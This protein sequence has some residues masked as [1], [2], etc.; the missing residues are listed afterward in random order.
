[1]PSATSAA[2]FAFTERSKF[3]SVNAATR[4]LARQAACLMSD[5]AGIPRPLWSR[6]IILSDPAL[7]V[8]LLAPLAEMANAQ[9][10]GFG[11]R[12]IWHFA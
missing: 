10:L 9:G 5:S 3:R 12:S 7:A 2:G 11:A 6:Q 8:V 1:M 4:S